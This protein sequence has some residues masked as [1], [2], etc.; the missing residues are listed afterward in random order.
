MSTMSLDPP[1]LPEGF[2]TGTGPMLPGSE[3][4]RQSGPAS[5]AKPSLDPKTVTVAIAISNDSTRQHIDKTLTAAELEIRQ[6]T[7]FELG[8]V[9][10]LGGDQ[11]RVLEWLQKYFVESAPRP[12]ILISDLLKAPADPID[13]FLTRECQTRFA[14]HALGTIA[15]MHSPERMTDIDRT[16]LPD[17]SRD[18]FARAMVLLMGRLEY[19]AVPVGRKDVD[20]QSIIIRPLRRDNETEFRDYFRLRH[21][22]YSQMGYLDQATEDSSG[23]LEMNE[24]DVHSIHLGAFCRSGCRL[25]GAAR[26]VTSGEADPLL[27][28]L[29]G[30][31]AKRDPIAKRRLEEAYPL[32]LPIFQTHREMNPIMVDIY[33]K[34]QKCG[35]LSRVIV[36]R[37]FRGNGVSSRLVAEALQSA[38]G[39]GLK[40]IFLECLK[41]H[42]HLYE[43]HGFKRMPGLEASVV[44][45]KRTMIAMELQADVFAKISA[46]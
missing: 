44:D 43:M 21:Q 34:K 27:V 5:G 24:A 4:S 31:I 26:V 17:V 38:I 7:S 42:E 46:R 19:L 45:V 39:Q 11:A 41:I 13:G 16:I 20:P 18:D 10:D 3:F 23:K 29:F 37:T 1:A 28:K 6:K 2:I 32:G 25:I 33:T 8:A 15:V 12:L 9:V 36:D 22:V 40:R 30:V 14:K 35:E